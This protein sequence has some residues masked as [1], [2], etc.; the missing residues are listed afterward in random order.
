MN[1]ILKILLIIIGVLVTILGGFYLFIHIAFDG[2]FTGPFHNK[3]DLINNYEEKKTEINEVKAFINSKITEDTY[4]HIE[5]K[6]DGLGIFHIEKNGIYDSNWNLD[7]D[8]KK[9]DSLLTVIGWTNN[10]LEILKNKLD[11][12]NCI[13]ISNGSPTTVGWQRS[14]MGMYF[15]NIFDQNLSES[16]KYEYNGGCTHSFYKD[17]VVL[18]YGGGAIGSQCF[19][20]N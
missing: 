18:E 15:Y 10:E 2:I 11:A 4:I 6:N 12:A 17:N 16:L 19:P 13:S 8:S 1:R 20:S 14:G 3:Q 9:T 7:I 5:F